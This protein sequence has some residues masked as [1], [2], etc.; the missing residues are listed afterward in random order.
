MNMKKLTSFIV[1]VLY[2]SF[3]IAR[4]LPTPGRDAPCHPVLGCYSSVPIDDFIPFMY[5]IGLILAVWIIQKRDNS[6]KTL[7]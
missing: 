7:N 2:G 1:F 6:L 5:F 3:A 4:D